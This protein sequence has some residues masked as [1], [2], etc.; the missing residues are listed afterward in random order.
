MTS[1]PLEKRGP[2][3]L[4]RSLSYAWWHAEFGADMAAETGLN[5]RTVHYIRMHHRPDSPEL[6]ALHLVDEAS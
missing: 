6:A 5:E 2:G 1:Y 4:R 3:R